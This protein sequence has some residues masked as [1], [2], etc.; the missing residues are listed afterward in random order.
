MQR[1][2]LGDPRLS[3]LEL[4]NALRLHHHVD[5]IA[6][7]C[8]GGEQV[9]ACLC[10]DL[11]TNIGQIGPLDAGHI[12]HGLADFSQQVG[13]VCKDNSTVVHGNAVMDAVY[14]G[15]RQLFL[16]EAVPVNV[17]ALHGNKGIR[18]VGNITLDVVILEL[19]DVGQIGIIVCGTCQRDGI[20]NVTAA[21]LL[22]H[23]QLKLRV[24]VLLVVCGSS[25][26]SGDIE[27]L[28]PCVGSQLVTTRLRTANTCTAGSSSGRARAATASG[29]GCSCTCGSHNGQKCAT[30]D[31]F[32]N[33]FSFI[34][35]TL[36]KLTDP[37]NLEKEWNAFTS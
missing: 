7:V 32:H 6:A 34:H 35:E 4:G 36:K 29:Q 30:R 14:D 2:V 15:V 28:I 8:A 12:V 27:I 18:V 5:Q 3:V 24:N 16:A 17:C 1:F 33:A 13:A 20:L 23:L 25:V 11:L 22:D 31:L 21:G 26:Q 37:R 9:F 10:V 19:H